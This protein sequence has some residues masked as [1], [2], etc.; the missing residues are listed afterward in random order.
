M[1]DKGR[2]QAYD[3]MC[4]GMKKMTYLGNI[5]FRFKIQIPS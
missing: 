5:K 4:R 3:S 1:E 2:I